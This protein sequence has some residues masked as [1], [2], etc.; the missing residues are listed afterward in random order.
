MTKDIIRCA[1]VICCTCV[2]C[3]DVLLEKLSF[4]YVIMDEATLV[5]E[6]AALVPVSLGAKA[7]T[8]IGDPQQLSP[9]VNNK[10]AIS[11]KDSVLDELSTSLFHRL[12]LLS[13]VLVSFMNT[14]HRMHPALSSFPSKEFYSNRLLNGVTAADRVPPS[15]PWP[16]SHRP[17]C[18]I[19]EGGIEERVGT[20]F[21]NKSQS[22]I[23]AD[24]VECLLRGGMSAKCIGVLTFYNAQVAELRNSVGT[25]GC[26]V[27]SV[28]S[29]QGKEKDV[30]IFSTV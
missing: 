30:I 5:I 4:D 13:P 9:F 18:F 23:I 14:Q 27:F 3:G 6:S 26:D 28:D 24:V 2:G 1:D 7:L 15:F 10:T 25:K 17:L 16:D 12:K 8:L 11:V 22:R 29:F 21:V 20:S 19:D